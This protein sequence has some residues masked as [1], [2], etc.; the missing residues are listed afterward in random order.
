[1]ENFIVRQLIDIT[2]FRALN[3]GQLN[4]SLKADGHFTVRKSI[5]IVVVQGGSPRVTACLMVPL[6]IKLSPVNS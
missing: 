2:A 6:E 5:T 4:T 1:M 3:N